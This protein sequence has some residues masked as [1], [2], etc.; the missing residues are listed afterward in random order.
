[1]VYSAFLVFFDLFP[2][3]TM[4]T[5]HGGGVMYGIF[6]FPCVFRSL[7]QHDCGH[8]AWWEWGDT[9]HDPPKSTRGL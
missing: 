2:N 5:G 7:S 1:M 3:M 6:G 9:Q 8:R 4:D